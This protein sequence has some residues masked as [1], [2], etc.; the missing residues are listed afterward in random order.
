M[1]QLFSGFSQYYVLVIVL[2]GICAFHSIRKGTQSK[3]IWIIVFLPL[4]GSLAYIFTE[5]IQKQ[6]VSTV[7]S[8]VASII[9][10]SGRIRKLERNLKFS[11]TLANRSALADAYL[12]SG[13]YAQAA[14]H[15]ESCLTLAFANSENVIMNLIQAYYHLGRFEDIIRLAPR[16]VHDLTFIKSPASLMYAIAL[17]KNGHPGQADIEYAKLNLRFSNYE[18]RY[19]YGLFLLSSGR[20]DDALKVLRGIEEEAQHMTRG[21]M[22]NSKSWIQKTEQTLKNMETNSVSNQM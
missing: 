15:Y 21:E 5:I 22:G 3:W 10:P 18:A 9:N 12:A 4:I 7:Q 14:H 8:G 11:D 20:R 6:H 16:V 1:M 17:E 2:Q 19:R 13:M